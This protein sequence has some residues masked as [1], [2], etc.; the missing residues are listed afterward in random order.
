MVRGTLVGSVGRAHAKMEIMYIT[1]V[2]VGSE[3]P[4]HKGSWWG[5]HT[6][7]TKITQKWNELCFVNTR[8][9]QI[10]HKL[11]ACALFSMP[12]MCMRYVVHGMRYE[13]RGTWYVVQGTE[14]VVR[15]MRYEVQNTLY[16]YPTKLTSPRNMSI[17][18]IE[19]A[20]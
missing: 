6:P 12:G 4:C 13:V 3:P 17:R 8:K 14:Y 10:A 5:L 9:L 11:D 19:G 18:G 1:W 7:C 16:G 15:G 20:E 2:P